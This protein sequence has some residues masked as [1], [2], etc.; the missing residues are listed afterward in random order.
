M[1]PGFGA[2]ASHVLYHVGATV[3]AI[4]TPV[5]PTGSLPPEGHATRGWRARGV[6][7]AGA[8]AGAAAR[9]GAAAAARVPARLRS[10]SRWP[11][12]VDRPLARTSGAPQLPPAGS[13]A[14]AGA[15]D[16]R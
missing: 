8:G 11:G 16:R 12:R 1:Q 13:G 10:A 4:W 15:S 2:V 3:Y 5:A 7:M 9:L 14:R 6:G